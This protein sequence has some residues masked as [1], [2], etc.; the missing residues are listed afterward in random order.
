[1]KKCMRCVVRGR[2]QG[3]WFRGSTQQQAQRLGINGSAIN[4]RDGSV[5]VFA[6]GSEENLL[7]L[8]RW[9]ASGPELARVDSLDCEETASDATEGF[10]TG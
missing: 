10:V 6:C 7:E 8:R 1:M 9:L 5:E 4:L 2:V 3:V